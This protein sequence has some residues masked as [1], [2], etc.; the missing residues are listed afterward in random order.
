MKWWQHVFR[1]CLNYN[2]NEFKKCY[3]NKYNQ[4]P[5]IVIF[6]SKFGDFLGK[7]WNP[8]TKYSPFFFFFFTF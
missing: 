5:N 7:F 3:Q 6:F 1:I 4:S 8:V 2:K